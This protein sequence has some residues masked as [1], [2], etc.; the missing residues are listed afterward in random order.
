[1]QTLLEQRSLRHTLGPSLY[2]STLPE[3][4]IALL[5][6]PSGTKVDTDTVVTIRLSGGSANA[7]STSSTGGQ[8]S[9]ATSLP[10]VI[11]QSGNRAR[12]SLEALGL[13]VTVEGGSSGVVISQEPQ[14]GARVQPGEHVT[15][16]TL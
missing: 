10:R 9:A 1:M 3:G 12:S 14:A 7:A 16:R 13:H 6:P 8:G 5:D 4:K 11:G 15:I 2:G